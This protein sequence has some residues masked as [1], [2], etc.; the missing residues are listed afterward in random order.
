M[1]VYENIKMALTSLRAHK[2]RSILTMLGIIIGVASVI[3]VVAI[4]QAGEA[5]LK[6]QIVGETNTTELLYV[7]PEEE[8]MS[9]SG[10]WMEDPFTVEDIQLIEE[11]PEVKRVVASSS[12][13]SMV[14]YREESVDALVNGISQAYF[15]INHLGIGEG[16][17]LMAEDFL[18][19]SRKAMISSSLKKEL[20]GEKEVL[21][22]VLYIA[23]Q[24]VEIIGV[25][26]KETVFLALD[27]NEI[28][29][30]WKTWQNIYMKSEYSQVT[31]EAETPEELQIAG[32]KAAEL[33]NRI[34]D[35]DQAYQVLNLEELTDGIGQITNIMTIVIGS[36]AGISLLIGGIGVMNIML[37]S[38]TE[39]TREIGIRMSLGA[40]PGQILFQFLVESVTLTL[41]GGA[42]GIGIGIASASV[43]AY[44]AGWPAL[45]S[46]QVILGG[47][48]FSMVIGVIF[49][50]LPANKAARLDPIESL[51]YE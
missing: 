3:A 48:L 22:E 17:S 13:S 50:I 14:R 43:V 25:L 35:K 38:V 21:G 24:P 33:L 44:I 10:G 41:I 15:E 19:G 5:M 16:R 40:T 20:F 31:I 42:I 39:R 29:I 45:I 47:L 32:T 51:R 11:I 18:G 1:S 34:H 8:L 23:S 9:N 28:Y 36:I 12:E 7:P 2:L 27:S 46:W 6:S 49:G 26:S 30:P 37:V 4:G